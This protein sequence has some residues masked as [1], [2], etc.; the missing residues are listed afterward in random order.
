MLLATY[1]NPAVGEHH[2]LVKYALAHSLEATI[3]ELEKILA[4]VEVC[5]KKESDDSWITNPDRMGGCYSE[6]ELRNEGWK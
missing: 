5:V 4:D 3:E 1:E 6:D 2:K